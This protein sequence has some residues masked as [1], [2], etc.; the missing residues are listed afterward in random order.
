M[1]AVQM[2][3]APITKISLNEECSSIDLACWTRCII[4]IVA[5]GLSRSMI[6]NS[7]YKQLAQ[8][9]RFQAIRLGD[10]ISVEAGICACGLW[11]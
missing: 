9:F 8:N 1:V 3:E 10:R 11:M 6:P 2:I 4:T 5:G 7:E